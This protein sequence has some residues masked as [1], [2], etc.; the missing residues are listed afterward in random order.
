[1]GLINGVNLSSD[2]KDLAKELKSEYKIS[3]FESLS[4]VLKVEQNELIK[5]GFLISSTDSHPTGLDEIAM[6]LGLK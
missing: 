5:R 6:A 4:L 2:V 3:D 1:M